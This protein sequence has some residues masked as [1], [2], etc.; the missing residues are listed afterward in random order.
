MIQDMAPGASGKMTLNLRPGMY[1][2]FCNITGH[3]AAG[4]HTMLRVTGG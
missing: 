3:F 4:Q 2:L 1:M